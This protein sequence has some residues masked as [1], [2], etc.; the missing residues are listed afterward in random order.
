MIRVQSHLCIGWNIAFSQ[1]ADY[2]FLYLS[3]QKWMQVK[4]HELM[5]IIVVSQ[6][7]MDSKTIF[8]VSAYN[9]YLV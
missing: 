5:S 9:F 3:L 7:H 2:V 1:K 8:P 6:V 4:K